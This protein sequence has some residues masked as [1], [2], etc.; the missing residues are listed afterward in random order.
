LSAEVEC[1]E[2]YVV[3][4]HKGHPAAVQEKG[5][6]GQRNRLKGPCGRGT[7]EKEKPPIF[8]MIQRGGQVVI[9]MIANVKQKTIEPLIKETI[10]PG[11]RVY[12]DEY[13]RHYRF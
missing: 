13:S 10:A 11:T 4:G 12:T 6:K 2:A 9:N 8:G 7:L 3:A 1:D 5:R